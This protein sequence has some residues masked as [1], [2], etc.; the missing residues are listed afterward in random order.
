L[1]AYYEEA[2]KNAYNGNILVDNAS[3]IVPIPCD[4]IKYWP[5]KKI[6]AILK[7]AG[8]KK[9][10]ITKEDIDESRKPYKKNY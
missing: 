6:N 8:R 9:V 5:S 1:A 7:K 4:S 10:K 2:L 3:P